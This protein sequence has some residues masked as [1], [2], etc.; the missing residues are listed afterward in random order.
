MAN[1]QCYPLAMHTGIS[2]Q[3]ERSARLVIPIVLEL[4]R[5]QSVVDVGCGTGIWLSVF[6]ECGVADVRGLDGPYNAMSEFRVDRSLFTAVDFEKP[7][8][9]DRTF[10]CA[11]SLEVAEH[12][13]PANADR[14]V[15]SLVALAPLVLFSAAIPFQGGYQHV[16]EQ[17]PEYWVE[18]FDRHGYRAV[19]VIR[20]RVW[21]ETGIC[22]Y[23]KQNTLLFVRDD[24][25]E[26]FPDLRA[27]YETI[28]NMP[29]S[30]VHPDM[31]LHYA[32]PRNRGL[33]EVLGLVA[34]TLKAAARRWWGRLR[35]VPD[36]H[37]IGVAPAWEAPRP[38]HAAP[39]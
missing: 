24:Q 22:W 19:D 11:V 1:Q 20:P 27:L 5:P 3:T 29:M 33:R 14:F 10:D 37:K 15:Q 4:C 7:F 13:S 25:F 31:Y 18:R 2:D 17:W 9:L 36:W 26:R 23:T 21:N 39:R 8:A 30:L 28:R 6:Q 16:N 12:V 32:D 38:N 35:G 34:G